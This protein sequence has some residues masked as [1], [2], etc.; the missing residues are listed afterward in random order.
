LSLEVVEVEVGGQVLYAGGLQ[1]VTMEEQDVILL[2][3]VVVAERK[4][5]V[6]MAV[7]LGLELLLED[8]QGHLDKEDKEAI[9]KQLLVVVAVVDFTEAVEVEMTVVVQ[10]VTAAAAAAAVLHLFQPVVHVWPE[11]TLIM[12]M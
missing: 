7:R 3:R 12:V 10:V 1:I 2:V 9:G 8:K 4:L 6:G 5:Q 11:V